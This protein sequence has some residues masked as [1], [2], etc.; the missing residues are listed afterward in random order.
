MAG[1]T[2]V[3]QIAFTPTGITLPSDSDIRTGVMTD[4][5]AAF[6]GNLNPS[7]STPQ[8]QLVTSQ[9]AIIS[10]KNAA[11]AEFMNQID[12]ATADGVMQDAIGRIYFMSRRPATPT[13]VQVQCT[14]LVG[15]TIPVGALVRDASG[16][17]YACTQAGIIPSTGAVVLPFACT[18]TGPTPCPAG[19]ITGSPYRAIL[20]WD[21][22]T[23]LTDGVLGALV[24]NRAEFEYRR[25][26]S[27]A[28][29][30]HGSLPSIYANVFGA[31]GVLDVYVAE[32]NE[33]AP[34]TL[35]VTNYPLA[36]HSIYVAAF[37]GTDADV[38][39][40]IWSTKD[41]GAN[42][43]GNT[44]VTV[45]DPSGYM[46]PVPTYTV[47]FQRPTPVPIYFAVSVQNLGATPNTTIAAAIRAM[48]V[49]AFA[50]G[51]GGQR[52]RIGSTIF[53]TRYFQAVAGAGQIA[54]L[55]LAI[56]KHA[57]AGLT[58]L[59]L[60]IDENPTIDPNNISV[61]FL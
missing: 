16:S 11:F 2:S 4:M 41:T 7:L 1:T 36:A 32:N 15:V 50:G 10:A 45:Q 27:V 39:F 35:G 13:V 37:G 28:I 46:N 26:Q 20:G 55:S 18:A 60:G 38:A 59:T 9:A 31:A 25:Q 34:V 54:V 19:S 40:A 5:N 51:D 23:N 8:G 49:S 47:K 56:D 44:T 29:N 52:A 21:R 61:T 58:S 3:P 24:E 22:A 48:V 12:P 53:A 57:P 43:N 6:G 33:D 14:G 17:I 42:Y 30:A